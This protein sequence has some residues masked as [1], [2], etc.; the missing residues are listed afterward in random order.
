MTPERVTTA[1][2]LR[3]EDRLTLDRIAATIG[4]SRASVVRAL[5]EQGRP[6]P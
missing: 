1:R 4:V 5:S 2:R 6:K 3:G